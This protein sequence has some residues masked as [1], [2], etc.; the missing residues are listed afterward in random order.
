MEALESIWKDLQQ[1]VVAAFAAL[2][3]LTAFATA[4]AKLTWWT[5][6]DD[7]YADR[8]G[9]WYW[10]LLAWMPTIG[11]NPQTKALKAAYVELKAE[12]GAG[13]GPQANE[14]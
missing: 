11:V 7:H 1:F 10:G 2:G 8:L 12:K 6:R 14:V 3:A 13:D 4:V 9:K 5:K